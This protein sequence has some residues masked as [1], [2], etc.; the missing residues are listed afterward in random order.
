LGVVYHVKQYFISNSVVLKI[1]NSTAVCLL[2][3]LDY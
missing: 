3:T 1:T 2:S